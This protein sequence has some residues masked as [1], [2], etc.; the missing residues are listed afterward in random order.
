MTWKVVVTGKVQGVFF[1]ASTKDCASEL[2]LQG[3]VRNDPDGTV[4]IVVQGPEPKFKSFLK[5]AH[6][7]PDHARVD[8]V[9]WEEIEEEEIFSEFR[10]KR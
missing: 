6:K 9:D 7:G 5:W 3:W 2:G 8:Q 1:R 10:V 4:R